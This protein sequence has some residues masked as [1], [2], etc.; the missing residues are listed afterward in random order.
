MSSAPDFETAFDA[1]Q[2]GDG[3]HSRMPPRLV[4]LDAVREHALPRLFASHAHAIADRKST[5]PAHASAV[6][7][8][9]VSNLADCA[10]S[11]DLY[12]AEAAVAAIALRGLSR[13]ELLVELLLPAA[14]ALDERWLR[15]EATFADVALA[16]GCLHRLLRSPALPEPAASHAQRSGFVLVSAPPGGMRSFEAA[17]VADFFR[18]GLWDVECLTP[19]TDE[20]LAE[21]L[22]GCSFDL[23]ALA[24]GP[25]TR[26]P[27]AARLIR[28]MRGAS[29][30]RALPILAIGAA[31]LPSSRTLGADASVQGAE[32]AVSAAARLLRSVAA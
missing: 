32:R 26:P 29:A 4:L 21:R 15:D 10:A 23:L 1:V 25:R 31:G 24:F 12:L 30:N 3:R 19:R 28:R 9:D 18:G 17:V 8:V 16:M 22:R 27:D 6:R 11:P 13:A 5:T 7:P 2:P 20:E 14:R